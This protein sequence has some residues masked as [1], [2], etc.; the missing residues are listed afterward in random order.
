MIPDFLAPFANH[1]WQST[2]FAGAAGLLALAL[3]KNRARVR[4]GVWLA[5][6]CK[7]LVPLS[8]LM[9]L[10]GHLPRRAAPA[11]APSNWPV[12]VDALSRPF[13]AL[14][15]SAPWPAAPPA[16]SSLAPLAMGIWACGFLGIAGAWSV[17]WRRIRAA[18]RAGSPLRLELPIP[19]KSSPALL[20]PGVFGIFRPVLLLPQGIFDRLTPAQLNAVIAHELCHVR[21]RDN[22]MAALHMFVETIFWFHPMV[23]WIGSRMVAERERA[24][25]EEVLQLGNEPRAYA[26]GIL[27]ICK[28]Y[29]ESPLACVSGV[30]GADLTNRIEAIMRNRAA[31]RLSL[32]KK[33]ALAAAGVAALGAPV[34]LGMLHT[35]AVHAQSAAADALR[36]EVASVKRCTTE[37]IANARGR[38]GSGGRGAGGGGGAG[39][40]FGD[41]G[42][43]RTGCVPLRLLL[44]MAYI[45]YAE[46]QAGPVSQLKDGPVLGGPSWVDS[47]RYTIDAKPASPQTRAVMAGPMLQA[48]LEDR[49]RLKLHRERKEVPVYALAVAKGGPKLERTKQGGCTPGNPNSLPPPVVPGQ[50]LPC[51][52]IDGAPEGVNAVG[53]GVAS[54]CSLIRGQVGRKVIDRTGLTGLFNYHLDVVVGPPGAPPGGD[55]PN[56][57]DPL[58]V[59]T[60]ALAK[61]GLKIEPAKGIAEFLVIDHVE[62]PSPN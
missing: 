53:V 47:E 37:D 38:A 23:W 56:A 5:A 57:P 30:T 45:R 60:A 34:A 11:A 26:E 15:V 32:A 54:I 43:L 19:A 42:M 62:R 29:V 55:D 46:G 9:A 49:F 36:F 22:L 3:R 61:L 48:L 31:I 24:C 14:P 16:H 6:S 20:E 2:L 21:H 10:G 50:P 33:A 51:G 18:V 1:L 28:L 40:A 25:D 52:Y 17:R 13:T 12:A 35:P 8:L 59:V 44:Q 4:H 41:P 7:F 58:S 27:N 39:S